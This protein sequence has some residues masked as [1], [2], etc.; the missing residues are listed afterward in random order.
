MKKYYRI[1]NENKV[2]CFT[3]KAIDNN[4]DQ[5]CYL[6]T[7]D[8]TGEEVWLYRDAI[9]YIGRHKPNKIVSAR[10]VTHEYEK[11]EKPE[12]VL[13]YPGQYIWG[14]EIRSKNRF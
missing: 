12:Q 8:S 7:S 6:A 4:C 11:Y 10:D 14:G 3:I 2:E 13:L 5:V 1:I 9:E